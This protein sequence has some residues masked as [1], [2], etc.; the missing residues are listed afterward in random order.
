MPPSNPNPPT[1]VLYLQKQQTLP[2]PLIVSSSPSLYVKQHTTSFFAV[3]KVSLT[4]LELAI[5][6][7][8]HQLPLSYITTQPPSPLEEDAEA[9]GL[10]PSGFFTPFK[11]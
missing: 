2:G 6:T 11:D 1:P 10:E 9:V 5:S 3:T 7:P 4:L 8:Y